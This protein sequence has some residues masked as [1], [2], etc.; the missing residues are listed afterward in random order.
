MKGL[1]HLVVCVRDLDEAV[2]AYRNLGFTLTPRGVH[3]FGTQNN[4]V[5]LD[6]FFLELL[7]IADADKI[8]PAGRDNFSFAAFDQ[9]YLETREGAAM[10]VMDSDDFR[11]DHTA[12]KEKGLDTWPVFEFSR[13]ARQ[14]D[15]STPTVSFGLNFVTHKQMPLAAFFTC[16]Q[17][18][19][20]YFWKPEYQSHGNTAGQI[21]E[22][23][24]V[25]DRPSEYEQFFSDFTGCPV[26]ETSDAEV[27]LQSARG[28]LAI[29]TGDVFEH[30]Y[31]AEAP[32][33]QFGPQISGCLI[34]VSDLSKI[35]QTRV[36]LF[37]LA[38]GFERT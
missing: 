12:A 30:R 16:Q 11:A 2:K 7:S 10:L 1:D 17:F 22:V 5:Q 8:P 14:P 36:N 29:M 31:Q 20:Q 4:L 32:D 27:V 18:A 23:A 13:I 34:G 9:N 21:I 6:G 38:L 15:G 19:P 35:E 25:A 37:G 33:M 24:I 3:P 26:V 28:R